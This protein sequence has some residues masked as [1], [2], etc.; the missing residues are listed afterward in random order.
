[1]KNLL[2]LLFCLLFSPFIYAQSIDSSFAINGMI[3]YGTTGNSQQNLG[4]G[5]KCAIQADGKIVVAIDK[6]DPNGP[7]DLFFYTYRYNADGTTDSSFGVN[8]ASRI[9]AGSSSRNR[10]IKVQAD[11]KIIAVGES[12]YCINGI[13]GAPQFVMLRILNN[14]KVD[15]SFGTNGTVLSKDIFSNTGTYAN[16]IRVQINADGKYIICGRGPGATQ[17]IAR[18]QTNGKLDSSFAN[19]GIYLDNN[20]ASQFVDLAIDANENIYALAQEFSVPVDTLNYRNIIVTKLNANGSL[21]NSFGINGKLFLSGGNDDEPTSIKVRNDG[22]IFIIGSLK[23]F[24]SG[25]GQLEHGFVYCLNSDGS[26]SNNFPNGLVT[27]Q[28]DNKPTIFSGFTIAPNGRLMIC[29]VGLEKVNGNYIQKSLL[30]MMK[31]DGTLDSTFNN[32]GIM[33]FDH[34]KVSAIGSL[35][36]FLDVNIINNNKLICTGFRNPIAGNVKR[37]VYLLQLKDV[38][39][40]IPSS[41]NA[42][43][44]AEISLFPNPARDVVFINGLL[45]EDFVVVDALGRKVL[46]SSNT[47]TINISQ[48]PVGTY[49]AIISSKK[50]VY[51]SAFIKN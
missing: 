9:F 46:Q 13:C 22:K 32:N 8:G 31:E 7:S 39:T 6:Y 24:H 15:S 33:K 34:C 18:L 27:M 29:G 26:L 37:S 36:W 43:Y 5:N 42:T 3:P 40:S 11:G 19:M 44:T 21:N 47:N 2:S 1:M 28:A 50:K 14:G 25:Y 10:D 16:P 17:F 20:S 48:L 4:M 12:E 23:A 38:N 35:C 30:V 49:R 41:L 45:A 51:T